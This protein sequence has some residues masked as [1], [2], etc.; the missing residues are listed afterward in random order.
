MYVYYYS[1]PRFLQ[2]VN[3]YTLTDLQA[4]IGGLS[5]LLLGL[6]IYDIV[7]RVNQGFSKLTK[8]TN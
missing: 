5:G 8:S 1:Y 3:A 7:V 2:E 6:S 4:D